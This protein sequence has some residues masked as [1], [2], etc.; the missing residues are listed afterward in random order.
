MFYLF[1]RNEVYFSRKITK[2]TK[3]VYKARYVPVMELI[4]WFVHK[5]YNK[6]WIGLSGFV[7]LGNQAPYFA[8]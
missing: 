2:F 5:C 7:H 3:S 8:I 6:P 4:V 1:L